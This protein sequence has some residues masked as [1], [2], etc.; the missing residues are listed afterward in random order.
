MK[1]FFL[2]FLILWTGNIYSQVDNELS[3]RLGDIESAIR[4][5]DSLVTQNNGFLGKAEYDKIGILNARIE[6]LAKDSAKMSDDIEAYRKLCADT[7][8]VYKQKRQ[9]QAK[10]DSLANAY[11]ILKETYNELDADRRHVEEEKKAADKKAE[12]VAESLAAFYDKPF[13]EL[14]TDVTLASLN[15]DQKE[16]QH[17]KMDVPERLLN[18]KTFKE[19]EL[20]LSKPYSKTSVDAYVKRL[21]AISETSAKVKNLISHLSDYDYIQHSFAVD[22]F[23]YIKNLCIENPTG[24]SDLMKER[25]CMEISYYVQGKL[26]GIMT[27]DKIDVRNDYPYIYGMI[28]DLLVKKYDNPDKDITDMINKLKK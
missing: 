10:V 27:S 20:L 28:Q 22:M 11:R 24:D 3:S 23:S 25:R 26:N 16:M 8:V 18:L 2:V 7:A 21:N 19:A 17:L 14:C 1:K 5:I 13:D 15:A 9:L 6:K 12:T 4:H